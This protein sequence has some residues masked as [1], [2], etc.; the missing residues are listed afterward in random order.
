MSSSRCWSLRRLV[1]GLDC[2]CSGLGCRR[3]EQPGSIDVE[4]RGAGSENW[5]AIVRPMLAETLRPMSILAEAYM[6]AGS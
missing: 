4:V 6:V 1:L 5:D 2:I 3:I